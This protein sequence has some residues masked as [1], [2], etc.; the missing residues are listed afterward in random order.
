MMIFVDKPSSIISA[1]RRTIAPD[2]TLDMVGKRTSES[3]SCDEDEYNRNATIA[4]GRF[5][6]I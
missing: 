2:E 4:Y 6:R 1:H 5:V 3:G